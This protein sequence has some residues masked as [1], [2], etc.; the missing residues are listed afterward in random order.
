MYVNWS[1]LVF[2]HTSSKP[3]INN[4]YEM[5]SCVEDQKSQFLAG[6]KVTFTCKDESFRPILYEFIFHGFL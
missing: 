2:T 4:K 5:K 6:K 3:T 1:Y